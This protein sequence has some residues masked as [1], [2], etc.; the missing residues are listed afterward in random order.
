MSL[1]LLRFQETALTNSAI[2]ILKGS[3]YFYKPIQLQF[4]FNNGNNL[5]IYEFTVLFFI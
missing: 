5:K 3:L 1:L 2:K 4:V